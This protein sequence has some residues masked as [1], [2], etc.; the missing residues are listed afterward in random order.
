MLLAV[1]ADKLEIRS[2]VAH[3]EQLADDGYS[4]RRRMR[5][6][7]GRTAIKIVAE[8]SSTADE[9]VAKAA[10]TVDETVTKAASTAD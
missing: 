5:R 1:G 7:Q 10:S 2:L 4:L 8:S 9:T 6:G 3:A